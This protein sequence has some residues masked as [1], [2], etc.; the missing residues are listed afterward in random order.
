MSDFATTFPAGFPACP[1]ELELP[2][3]TVSMAETGGI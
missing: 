1:G 3:N 2:A